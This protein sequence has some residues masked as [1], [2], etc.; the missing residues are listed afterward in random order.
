MRVSLIDAAPSKHCRGRVRPFA[1]VV[2]PQTAG[3]GRDGAPANNLPFNFPP[4]VS[5]RHIGRP[6][7]GVGE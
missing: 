7:Y 6:F 5:P 3:G 1:Q 2:G 4:G